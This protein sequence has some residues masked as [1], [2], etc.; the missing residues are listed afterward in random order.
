M[1]V[2]GFNKTTTIAITLHNQERLKNFKIIEAESWNN[3]L[4]RV[5]D[6]AEEA[7]LRTSEKNGKK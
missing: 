1:S 7:K 2:E 3:V 5:L 4:G 6:T